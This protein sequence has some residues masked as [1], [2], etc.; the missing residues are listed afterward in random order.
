MASLE[1]EPKRQPISHSG[2][3]LQE[4]HW[5]PFDRTGGADQPSARSA[6]IVKV[7]FWVISPVEWCVSAGD[8]TTKLQPKPVDLG[9]AGLPWLHAAEGTLQEAFQLAEAR[10]HWVL[11]AAAVAV[12][13]A[14]MQP[15]AHE[16]FTQEDTS[17][18]AQ[19]PADRQRCWHS[20]FEVPPAELAGRSV[21]WT[22]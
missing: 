9:A 19:K 13:P 6:H 2:C 4:V 12:R 14:R 5:V 22:V 17:P 21:A 15:I 7:S 10:V 18:T 1:S 3:V 16:G 20:G 8:G 11:H